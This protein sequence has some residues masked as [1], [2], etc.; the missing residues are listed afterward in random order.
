MNKLTLILIVSLIGCE[1]R[2]PETANN[3]YNDV[4]K[5]PMD[6]TP[7]AK[8]C[9]R[10]YNC[11]EDLMDNAALDTVWS[12]NAEILKMN[13]R[14]MC[15][16]EYS[17][18]DTM[19]YKKNSP[20]ETDTV[21]YRYMQ[22]T[23]SVEHVFRSKSNLINVTPRTFVNSVEDKRLALMG[24][25][26]NSFSLSITKSDS[27]ARLRLPIYFREIE[28]G[29]TLTIQIDKNAEV[30]FVSSQRYEGHPSE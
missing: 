26:G 2:P 15:N 18:I 11:V 16:N 24:Y 6:V 21:I 22:N 5:K 1:A 3:L 4:T 20:C 13:L 30:K 9:F 23:L 17:H 7:K 10:D 25:F 29:E 28:M 8:S 14:L 19:V 12:E 27:S